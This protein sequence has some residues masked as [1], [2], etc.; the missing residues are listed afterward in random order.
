[1][2]EVS[3]FA[4]GSGAGNMLLRFRG[5]SK[6][7]GSGLSS[8]C[9]GVCESC[10]VFGP[11]LAM[12]CAVKILWVRA[13]FA[14][15]ANERVLESEQS[16]RPRENGIGSCS[17]VTWDRITVFSVGIFTNSLGMGD[18]QTQPF[19]RLFD[20]VCMSG[21]LDRHRGLGI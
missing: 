20:L 3:R 15:W 9:G 5:S 13:E 16:P 2:N 17:G 4:R 6:P 1:M 12:G 8:A 10:I 19:S 7:N 18:R 11:S 21:C 14:N